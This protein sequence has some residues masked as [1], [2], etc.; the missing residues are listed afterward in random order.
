[1]FITSE[2]G[3][4]EFDI[5]RETNDGIVYTYSIKMKDGYS[6]DRIA[7][8]ATDATISSTDYQDA[9]ITENYLNT[10]GFCTGFHYIINESGTELILEIVNIT[11][12]FI[13]YLGF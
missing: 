6:L 12:P 1:M 13:V 4:I 3:G 10:N 2:S 11:A 8:I 5:I 7:L 9:P